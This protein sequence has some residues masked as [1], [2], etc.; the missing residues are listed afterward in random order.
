MSSPL[1]DLYKQALA[2]HNKQSAGQP[3]ESRLRYEAQWDYRQFCLAMGLTEFAVRRIR[4]V[5]VEAGLLVVTSGK[6]HW[7]PDVFRPRFLEHE[8]AKAYLDHQV[9]DGSFPLGEWW[10]RREIRSY[11]GRKA[12]D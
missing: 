7:L 4:K 1:R 6:G 8:H 10:S 11:S 2:E 12:Q 5:L 3:E 9:Q